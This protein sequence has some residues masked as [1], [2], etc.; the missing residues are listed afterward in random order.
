MRIAASG[1]QSVETLALAREKVVQNPASSDF[2]FVILDSTTAEK[3]V[4]E[5]PEKPPEKM[6]ATA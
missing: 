1:H 5:P 6:K 3:T 2:A 4:I